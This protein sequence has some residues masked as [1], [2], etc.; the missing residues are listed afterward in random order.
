M[1]K[2]QLNPSRKLS[3]NF[4]KTPLTRRMGPVP[5]ADDM[6]TMEQVVSDG[7]QEVDV[8]QWETMD[9]F[10]EGLRQALI[11]WVN[12]TKE[13]REVT[14]ISGSTRTKKIDFQFYG[15]PSKDL[16]GNGDIGEYSLVFRY[17]RKI[18]QPISTNAASP[19]LQR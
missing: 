9:Q 16:V 18:I 3:A 2:L 4:S 7:N 10:D 15:N 13:G 12:Q 11:N 19:A 1:A 8:A 14:S 6:T 5:P 17:T